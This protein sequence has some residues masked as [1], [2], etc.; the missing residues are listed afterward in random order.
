MSWIKETD[1]RWHLNCRVSPKGKSYEH[2]F[3]ASIIKRE[4]GL[5]LLLPDPDTIIK[6]DMQKVNNILR[7]IE[8]PTFES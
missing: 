3:T 7:E 2:E 8:L 4:D 5:E 6:G 1:N